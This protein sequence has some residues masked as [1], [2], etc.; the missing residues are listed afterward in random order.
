MLWDLGSATFHEVR[1]AE[2]WISMLSGIGSDVDLYG[3][4]LDVVV[5]QVRTIRLSDI[6]RQAGRS[7]DALFLDVEGHELSV[8]QSNYAC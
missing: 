3:R 2:P 7:V 8:L 1:G 5:R 4:E 6:L